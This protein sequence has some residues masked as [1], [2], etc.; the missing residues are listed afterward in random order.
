MV[1]NRDELCSL[2]E[3][4][5][6]DRAHEIVRDRCPMAVVTHGPDGS[7]VISGDRTVRVA[8]EPVANVVDTTGAGD[9]YAA[10]SFRAG[11]RS[12]PGD[13]RPPRFDRRRRGHLPPGRTP[14]GVAGRVGRPRPEP[15]THLPAWDDASRRR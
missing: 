14:A 13:V 2:Y 1:A 11:H 10:G 8:A 3:T 6:I 7:Y 15:V 9:Q 5:D 12:R 4:D